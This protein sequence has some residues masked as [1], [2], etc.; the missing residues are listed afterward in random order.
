MDQMNETDQTN[1]LFFSSDQEGAIVRNR[2]METIHAT[3][4]E[5]SHKIM[6]VHVGDFATIGPGLTL[7]ERLSNCDWPDCN[8]I[9]VLGN[10]DLNHWRLL[11]V[12]DSPMLF[13]DEWPSKLTSAMKWMVEDVGKPIDLGKECPKYEQFV[14]LYKGA[15]NTKNDWIQAI[16]LF[17]MAVQVATAS[18]R[19]KHGALHAVA[20][21]CVTT[22]M[23][24][25]TTTLYES[26]KS[27]I[28]QRAKG[29]SDLEQLVR[30]WI[31]IKEAFAKVKPNGKIGP[32]APLYTPDDVRKLL[33]A[34]ADQPVNDP[35]DGIPDAQQAVSKTN[36]GRKH[37]FMHWEFLAN[38]YRQV[39]ARGVMMHQNSDYAAVHAGLAVPIV[40]TSYGEISIKPMGQR[41]LDPYSAAPLREEEF[42]VRINSEY[43]KAFY[44]TNPTFNGMIRAK[45]YLYL[46]ALSGVPIIATN[47]ITGDSMAPYPDSNGPAGGKQ[48]LESPSTPLEMEKVDRVF[49]SAR[50]STVPFL[51]TGHQPSSLG[52]I[53]RYDDPMTHMAKYNIRLDTQYHHHN[54]N[55][56]V[57]IH[58]SRLD[59]E[60]LK[61]ATKQANG[62]TVK[63]VWTLENLQKIETKLRSSVQELFAAN[64]PLD[65]RSVEYQLKGLVTC[66][67]RQYRLVVF[68]WKE[69]G[70]F[71]ILG[72]PRN[73]LD[74][75]L[76]TD[77]N[78]RPVVINAALVGFHERR[79]SSGNIK[80]LNVQLPPGFPDFAPLMQSEA[81][82]TRMVQVTSV[83]I[84]D[85]MK[86]SK[87][88][89]NLQED[90]VFPNA[91][92][93]I[94]GESIPMGVMV[95]ASPLRDALV[96]VRG[97]LAL[98]GNS[99][100]ASS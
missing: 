77:K 28:Y 81:M 90:D 70:G 20:Y 87:H 89:G 19:G 88:I 83:G 35:P 23:G 59:K 84:T 80:Y 92:C 73:D 45:H 44:H 41:G 100:G 22:M 4:K 51:F 25:V 1:V 26:E 47:P 38:M 5:Y 67:K 10:R 9:F 53:I 13:G 14:D 66:N 82:Q 42:S 72:I 43:R 8:D 2:M 62:T 48:W 79:D 6:D 36:E 34:M 64:V 29:T 57:A 27:T 97:R 17:E 58:D 24:G 61:E 86:G 50:L 31:T 65:G 85:I 55:L 39:F 76:E 49:D 33:T 75:K 95:F 40:P 30:Q 93:D 69:V 68:R 78:A 32:G 15:K 96:G 91:V 21:F 52:E 63:H 94:T 3:I 54:S 12:L 18:E 74:S 71:K 7:L 16:Q 60:L 56:C 98:Q 11:L 37:Y 99:V 46:A